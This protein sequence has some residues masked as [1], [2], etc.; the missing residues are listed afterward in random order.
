MNRTCAFLLKLVVAG[1]LRLIFAGFLCL[2]VAGLP[3]VL[4]FV[5]LFLNLLHIR[6]LGGV[7]HRMQFVQPTAEVFEAL[8]YL[9][10][11]ADGMKRS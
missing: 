7:L 8:V 5:L 6:P 9:P 10:I 2:I 4:G 1:L 11:R 3:R